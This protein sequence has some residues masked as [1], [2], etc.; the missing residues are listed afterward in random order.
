M[1]GFSSEIL[2]VLAAALA[3]YVAKEVQIRTKAKRAR[4]RREQKIWSEQKQLYYLPLLEAARE[5]RIRMEELS[6]VYRREWIKPFTPE[7]LSQDF[8]ELYALSRDSIR[9]PEC[10]PN[11]LR[12]NDGA[13]QSLRQRMCHYLNFATS[14]LYRT[15]KYLAIAEYVKRALNTGK[16]NLSETTLKELMALIVNVRNSLQGPTGAGIASEQQESIAEIMWDPAGHVITNFEFR[17]RLLELPGWEQFTG[18]LIFF[19]SEDD[20]LP[21]TDG[22]PGAT[23]VR[24]R[25]VAKVPCEVQETI[26]ALTALEKKLDQIRSF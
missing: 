5:F 9:L 19:L 16:L 8:R 26:T 22:K 12:L 6:R 25:F 21:V 2:K 17:K 1:A 3:G 20:T 10:D 13:R 7:S 14:S 24:A 23:D 11:H 15:A 4:E 18:L